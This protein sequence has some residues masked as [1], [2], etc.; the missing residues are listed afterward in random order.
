MHELRDDGK[1]LNCSHH[2]QKAD[3]SVLHVAVSA[4]LFQLDGRDRPVRYLIESIPLPLY[5]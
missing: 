4:A 2:H 5:L 1:G 3:G